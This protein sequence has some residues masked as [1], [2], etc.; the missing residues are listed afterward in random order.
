[1]QKTLMTQ[2]Q[3]PS[4]YEFFDLFNGLDKGCHFNSRPSIKRTL[5]IISFGIFMFSVTLIAKCC[6][7][8]LSKRKQWLEK[9]NISNDGSVDKR[10]SRRVGWV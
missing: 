7:P 6:Y 2:E 10:W 3:S 4:A 9:A 5:R 1:M 8:Q